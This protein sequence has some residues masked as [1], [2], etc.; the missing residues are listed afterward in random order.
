MKLTTDLMLEGLL[1]P[2]SLSSFSLSEWNALLREA[3]NSGVLHRIA[4]RMCHAGLHNGLDGKVRDHLLAANAEACHYER[5]IYWEVG[6]IQQTLASLN[7]QIVLLKGAAY[8][9]ADLPPARGRKVNDVDIMVPKARLEE[10]EQALLANGWEPL[11]LD[12]YDQRYY[13]TWMHELPP[14]KHRQRKTVIDVHHTI[15]PE[16]GRLHL[17]PAKLL[18]SARP[19]D[20]NGLWVLAPEDMVLHSAAHLFQDGDIA[21][22]LRDLLDLN[23][24]LRYFGGGGYPFWENI[25]P[26]ARELDLGRPLFY[27]LHFA[28][29]FCRTPVPDLV[30]CDARS[31]RPLLPVL[32]LMDFLVYSALF[33][34]TG[35]DDLVS[36]VTST[37]LYIR[38]HWLRMPP[39]LL[40]R[41]LGRKAWHKLFPSWEKSDV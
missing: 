23:D 41:H 5:M 31:D 21:G 36:N 15:L 27:A 19:L 10:V 13:R 12:P 2:S 17:D 7:V 37:A 16:S 29:K 32:K 30:M 1:N 4:Y 11:K 3:R 40:A 6:C 38:S 35:A 25:V 26:R 14:L 24:L 39:M 18:S 22:G 33:P 28:A 20:R 34:E 9:L 8:L